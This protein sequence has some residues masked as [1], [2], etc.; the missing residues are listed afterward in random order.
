MNLTALN[1]LLALHNVSVVRAELSHPGYSALVAWGL[2]VG[3]P[4]PQ[5]ENDATPRRDYRLTPSGVSLAK[6]KFR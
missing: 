5:H 1:A 3:R 4:F 6:E 2:A